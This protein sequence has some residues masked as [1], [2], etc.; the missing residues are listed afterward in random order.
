MQ[1]KIATW[2]MDYWRRK[3][4]HKAAWNCFLEEAKADIY[5]FQEGK[6]LAEMKNNHLI[7]EE[8]GGSRDWGSGIYTPKYE[9]TKDEIKT[10]FKGVYSV[11]NIK[12]N[13][14]K[15]TLISMYGL[16][17]S[18][19]PTKGYCMT[20]LHI[21][22]SELTGLFVGRIGGK[23]DI[24]L[25]GDLNASTQLNETLRNRSHSIFFDRV[26]DFGLR[27]VYKLSGNKD[28]VQTLRHHSSKKP[29]QNDYIF[30][31]KALSKKFLNYTIIDNE[32]V[33]K[34]SDHNIVTAILDV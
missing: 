8:I 32:K 34:F 28:Y 23:R 17:D 2:N 5:L 16:M 1:I 15:L 4:V 26:E 18:S 10:Q 3:R 33:R 22:L 20:N 7:W 6:P 9:L 24:I 25:G 13:D 19:G 14:R 30:I 11:G 12:I 21:M 31:S 27:D 29:W